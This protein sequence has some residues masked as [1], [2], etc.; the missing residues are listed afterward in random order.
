M[1]HHKKLTLRVMV[2][3]LSVYLAAVLTTSMIHI[4]P[5]LAVCFFLRARFDETKI[6]VTNSRRKVI[7]L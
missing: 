4:L 2:T 7:C 1:N 6:L 3:I 5:M